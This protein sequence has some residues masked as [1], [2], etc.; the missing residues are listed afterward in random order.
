MRKQSPQKCMCMAGGTF[1]EPSE[2]IQFKFCVVRGLHLLYFSLSH[3]RRR[4]S[5]YPKSTVLNENKKNT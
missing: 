3:G 5:A 1:G 2:L 4:E